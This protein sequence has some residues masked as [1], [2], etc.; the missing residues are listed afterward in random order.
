MSESFVSSI[1]HNM[2]RTTAVIA[3]AGTALGAFGI[4]RNGGEQHSALPDP[5]HE[6]VPGLDTGNTLP[7]SPAVTEAPALTSEVPASVEHHNKDTSRSL[8]ASN[9]TQNPNSETTVVP[10]TETSSDP[11]KPKATLEH[12]QTSQETIDKEG[13]LTVWID[14]PT[15]SGGALHNA[16]GELIGGPTAY[17]G[18]M[19]NPNNN[20]YARGDGTINTAPL[21]IQQGNQSG[22]DM[23]NVAQADRFILP[24]T[25]NNKDDVALY[26]SKGHSPQ[27]V[28]D[29][30]KASSLTAEQVRGLKLG[31]AV[32]VSG[33]PQDQPNNPGSTRR[34]T[35]TLSFAG[36]KNGLELSSGQ[37]IDA[38]FLAGMKSAD[39][40]ECGRAMSGASLNVGSKIAG[41][42]SANIDLSDAVGRQHWSDQLGVDLDGWDYLCIGSYGQPD[43]G[44]GSYEA[45]TATQS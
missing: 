32:D 25:S 19:G 28:L 10:T 16:S 40:S 26:V 11:S 41:I 22:T 37:V 3:L 21:T 36:T 9:T 4:S 35:L 43:L 42:V 23:H 38:M 31:Q 33:Y 7:D 44:N 8:P 18:L 5:T 1:K 6:T 12:H 13:V 30:Y 15:E 45:V 29:L 14:D 27:E 17:H 24:T 2:L 34:Q 39:G 20:R